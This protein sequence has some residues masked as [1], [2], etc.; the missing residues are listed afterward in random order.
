MLLSFRLSPLAAAFLAIAA[1]AQTASPA[2]PGRAVAAPPPA[3]ATATQPLAYHSPLADYQPFTQEDLLSWR[4][5]NDTVG[6]IGGWRAYA[7]ESAAPAAPGSAAPP[8]AVGAPSRPASVPAPA[9][10]AAAAGHGGHQ[11]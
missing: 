8:A 6:R 9:K 7:R 1:R 11:H 3:T 4:E 10:P 5:A 2:S